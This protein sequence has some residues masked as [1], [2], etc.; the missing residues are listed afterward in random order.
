MLTRLEN[1]VSWDFPAD[2]IRQNKDDCV[3]VRTVSMSPIIL[4]IVYIKPAADLQPPLKD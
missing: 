2:V 4:S 1:S 3:F